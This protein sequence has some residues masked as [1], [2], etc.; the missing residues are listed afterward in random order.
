[1]IIKELDNAEEK[2]DIAKNILNSLPNWFGRPESTQIYIN[3]SSKLPFFVAYDGAKPLG[4]VSMKESSKYAVEIFVMGVLPNYHK[5]GIGKSLINK[6]LQWAKENEYEFLQVKTLDESHPDIYYARTREFYK[7]V[8]FKPLESL[9][10]LW[11]EDNP[12]L[13][14]IQYIG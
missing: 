13:I 4:F 8:G 2:R 3:E 14:M 1:M 11:G 7:A 10:E 5:K 6:V 9:P 12:C